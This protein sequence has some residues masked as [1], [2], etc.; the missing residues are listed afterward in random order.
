MVKDVRKAS[1]FVT[2]I[3]S[4]LFVTMFILSWLPLI[5]LPSRSTL[6]LT[7]PSLLRKSQLFVLTSLFPSAKVHLPS[8]TTLILN[9][10]H[11]QSHVIAVYTGGSKSPDGD[12]FS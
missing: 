1:L 9:H 11:Y 6:H 8:L 10:F 3:Y 2:L 12:S 4:A 7:F 5:Y